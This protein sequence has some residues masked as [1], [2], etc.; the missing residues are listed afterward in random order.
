MNFTR[1]PIIETIITPREG[2]KLL[3]R[4][5]KEGKD[6]QFHVDAVEVITFGGAQFYRSLEKPRPFLVPVG[7]YE[8]IEVKENRV[9]L[10]NNV[11]D[12]AIKIGGGREGSLRKAPVD[13]E[14]PVLPTSLEDE[15][16]EETTPETSQQQHNKRRD[17]RHRRRPSKDREETKPQMEDRLTQEKINPV[18]NTLKE[19]KDSPSS[20]IHLIPPPT[21]LI[22]ET[23]QQRHKD[24]QI[25]QPV[26]PPSSG[27]LKKEEGESNALNLSTLS[28]AP[29]FPLHYS[30][31]SEWNYFL[32]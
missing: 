7:D 14:E 8:V 17:R 9:V 10:K 18:S 6:D 5:S 20:F 23:I 1:E 21:T 26:I 15:I 28:S 22:S 12:Q 25:S 16:Q 4:S 31:L 32:S 24:K 2:Y 27:D 11:F 29:S 13:Q 3:I 19:T 30:T